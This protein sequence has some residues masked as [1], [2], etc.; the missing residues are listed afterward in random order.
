MSG[1][2]LLRV[3]AIVAIDDDEDDDAGSDDGDNGDNGD[4][5]CLVHS[6]AGDGIAIVWKCV[7]AEE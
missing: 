3:A 1:M 4:N 2:H 6:S 5:E 7:F